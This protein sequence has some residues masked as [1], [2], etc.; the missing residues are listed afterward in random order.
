MSSAKLVPVNISNDSWSSLVSA[1]RPVSQFPAPAPGKKLFDCSISDELPA[2]EIEAGTAEEAKAIYLAA[3][4]KTI[5]VEQV[6]AI[7]LRHA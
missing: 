1:I 2:L 3:V 7:E 4:I 5:T 6:D